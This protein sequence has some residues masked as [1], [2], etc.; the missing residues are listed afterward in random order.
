MYIHAVQNGLVHPIDSSVRCAWHCGHPLELQAAECPLARTTPRLGCDALH[1]VP[2]VLVLSVLG[3]LLGVVAFVVIQLIQDSAPPAAFA[4][5]RSTAAFADNRSTLG[6]MGLAGVGFGVALPTWVLSRFDSAADLL[7][8]GAP[9]GAPA[10]FLLPILLT[11]LTP[12]GL[13]TRALVASRRRSNQLASDTGAAL[14][15]PPASTSAPGPGA[16]G[17][18][19]L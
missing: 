1:V 19:L 17:V 10:L 13:A 7:S 9:A 11:L 18:A 2:V 6:L 8:A 12:L 5:N 14:K 3:L 15:P 4:D 16:G